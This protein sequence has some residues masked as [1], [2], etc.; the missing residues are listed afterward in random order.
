MLYHTYCTIPH[1]TSPH[2]TLAW[3][4]GPCGQVTWLQE[5]TRARGCQDSWPPAQDPGLPGQAAR[6]SQD[7]RITGGQDLQDHWWSGH[8]GPL[9]VRT[10]RTTGGQ[11]LQDHWSAG[12]PGPLVARTSRIQGARRFRTWVARTSRTWVDWKDCHWL[13]GNCYNLYFVQVLRNMDS[14]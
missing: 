6:A 10:C 3:S 14:L 9:V 12:P 1:H 8:A 7:L 2:H 11:D 13:I 4:Q 5:V